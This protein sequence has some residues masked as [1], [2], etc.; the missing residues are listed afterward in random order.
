[1]CCFRTNMH[2]IKLDLISLA[3]ST[4]PSDSSRLLGIVCSLTNP[5]GAG[6]PVLLFFHLLLPLSSS[7]ISS[8]PSSRYYHSVV[9]NGKLRQLARSA[10]VGDNHWGACIQG[11]GEGGVE[12]ERSIC[13]GGA[14]GTAASRVPAESQ[15]ESDPDTPLFAVRAEMNENTKQWVNRPNQAHYQSKKG[16]YIQCEPAFRILGVNPF[17]QSNTK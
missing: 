13:C 9:V 14:R 15:S 6:S 11:L 12:R 2:A 8:A 5:G 4:L 10:A 16:G 17:K 7:S 1:M 3:T